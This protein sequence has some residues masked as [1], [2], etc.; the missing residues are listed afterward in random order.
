MVEKAPEKKEIIRWPGLS[1]KERERRWGRLKKLMK[2]RGLDCLVVF[3][4]KGRESFDRYL[5]NDRAGGIVIF[6]LDGEL[7]HLTWAAFDIPAHLE[8]TLRGEASWVSDVR[9]GANGAGVV[10]VLHEKGCEKANVGV[11]GLAIW[12]PGEMEGYVP[13]GTWAYIL[14][15]LP[16]ARFVDISNEFAQIVFVKSDE[17]LQLV[18]RAAEIGE[19]AAEE[20]MRVARP[21]VGENELYAAGMHQ[22]FLN[23]ANGSPSPYITPMI[24]HSGPDN[25][26]WGAPMWLL[27]GQP[28]RIIE[29]GDILQV[30]IFSRYG[31]ME[32][33]LQLAIAIGNVESVNKECAEI[34]RRS[35]EVGLQALCTGR[36][37]GEVVE[38]MEEPLKEAGAW[39]ITPLIHSLNP[40]CWVS[41]T[42]SRFEE[43]PG[44][45]RYKDVIVTP[46]IGRDMEIRPGTVWELEPNA[47]L[48]KHKVNIGGTV[49][50]TE[51]GAIELNILSTKMRIIS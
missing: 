30:E 22:L 33:Q 6:P 18:R 7:V 48:G 2:D 38:A 23:G 27:R 34:A 25:P 45:E 46:V 50:A 47:C 21:G 44:I 36:K 32:A 4:L 51:R 12:A 29:N 31:G 17:E 1:E 40:L 37:F 19:L 10:K 35:Y 41:E 14:E 43:L 49:I 8:S 3:G 5:T 13:Y 11:V 9:L 28:P 26:G 20:M 16:K 42:N 24:M 15:N 39:H